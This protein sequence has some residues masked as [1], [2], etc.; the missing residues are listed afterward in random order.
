MS[1]SLKVINALKSGIEAV[2]G[3]SHADLTQAVQALKNGYGAG[4]GDDTYYNWLYNTF[5]KDPFEAD[6]VFGFQSAA[7]VLTSVPLLDLSSI[8]DAYEM[9]K[10]CYKTTDIALKGTSKVIFFDYMCYGCTAL[11]TIGTFDFSSAES[12]WDAFFWCNALKNIDFVA[13]SIGCD[14]DFSYSG[15]LTDTS[16]QSIFGGLSSNG[17]GTITFYS[18]VFMR[19]M[20]DETLYALYTNAINNGWIIQ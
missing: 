15:L 17:A 11:E 1:D 12:A 2:T 10:G 6:N 16:V 20:T 13:E 7:E 18:D 9:F 14:V 8:E 5:I 3:E 19:I 4:S